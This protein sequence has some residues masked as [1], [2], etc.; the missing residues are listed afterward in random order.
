[1]NSEQE[2]FERS[3]LGET[4]PRSPWMAA[5]LSLLSPGLG[6]LYVGRLP[7]ALLLNGALALVIVVAFVLWNMLEF[8]P[9]LPFGLLAIGLAAL[10]LMTLLDVMRTAWLRGDRFVLREYNHPLAYV[11]FAAGTWFLPIV[12]VSGWTFTTQWMVVE[13]Q[14]DAMYPSV[15]E[16]ERL[17]V[18]R[19]HAELERGDMV[20]VDLPPQGRRIVRVVA[21]GG[22]EVAFSDDT[23]FVNDRPFPRATLDEVGRRELAALTGDLREDMDYFVERDSRVA[24]PSVS[25]RVAHMAELEATRLA[26]D[27]LF[28]L[29]DHRGRTSDSRDLGPVPRETVIGRPLYV[30][31]TPD[32]G[33]SD[34]HLSRRVGR[35]IQAAPIAP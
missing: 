10:V 1:M 9:L 13:V 22:D 35:R 4:A 23:L 17:L 34:A 32:G 20:V 7:E 18:H 16:G 15:L 6:W 28:V 11:L 2:E 12:I 14:D 24:W 27:E 31:S 29:H 25:P 19:G 8:F 30:W 26:D 3:Y 5:G 33:G 21:L